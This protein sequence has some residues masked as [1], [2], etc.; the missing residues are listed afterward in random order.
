MTTYTEIL[1]ALPTCANWNYCAPYTVK[2][3]QLSV[4]IDDMPGD[5]RDVY[6]IDLR[7]GQV[8]KMTYCGYNSERHMW[9]KA[10]GR[11]QYQ[12]PSGA[13]KKKLIEFCRAKCFEQFGYYKEI[14]SYYPATGKAY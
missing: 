8:E 11:Q 2:R 14:V 1:K 12:V 10:A 7:D 3:P 13:G 4:F 5:R 6:E 9:T